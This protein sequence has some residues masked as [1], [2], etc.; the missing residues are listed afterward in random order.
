[1]QLPIRIGT[2]RTNFFSLRP[3]KMHSYLDTIAMPLYHKMLLSN[4]LK[5][6]DS[7]T[8]RDWLAKRLV[9]LQD[10]EAE[11]KGVGVLKAGS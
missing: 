9:L 7:P 10:E 4:L 5:S 2:S 1:M 6:Q 8:I 11:G 3:S